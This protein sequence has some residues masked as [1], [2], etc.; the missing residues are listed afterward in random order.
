VFR[1]RKVCWNL[2]GG[3]STS[4]VSINAVVGQYNQSSLTVDGFVQN[5]AQRINSDDEALRGLSS[6]SRGSGHDWR[7]LLAGDYEYYRIFIVDN[8]EVER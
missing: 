8:S 2:E 7:L 6:E 5:D 4:P 3:R 1:W